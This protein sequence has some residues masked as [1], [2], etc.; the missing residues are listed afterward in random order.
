MDRL[1]LIQSLAIPNTTKILLLIMDGLGGLPITEG[2][3]TELEAANT[4][5]LDALTA[6]GVCG[7]SLPIAQGITPGSGP[8]HMALFGYDPLAYE[9]GRGVLEALGIGFDLHAEDVAARGNFCTLDPATGVITDRRAGRIPTSVCERLVRKLRA[10]RLPGVEVFVE[11]VEDYRF[12]LIL[13]GAGLTDGLTETDPQ[14]TGVAPLPVEPTRPEAVHTAGLLNDWLAEAFKLLADERPANGCTLRGI[15]KNP[16][17]PPMPQV[18][19]LRCGAIATYPMYRGIAKLA[20]MDVLPTGHTIADEVET[21]RAH[22]ADYDFF[23]FHVKKTDSAGED[24]DFAR[25][26]H[27]IEE[28]DGL[29][30]DILALNPDVVLVTGDHSTPAL[31]KAHSWHEL[32]VLLWS[33]YCR[34]DGVTRFGERDCLAGG[35]GHIHHLDL[36]PLA[37]AHAGRLAKFGA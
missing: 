22:W 31:W 10:I 24:G 6:R 18:Y 19:G 2:G 5:N 27:V 15:A 29:L 17:L 7:M 30:P 4:P 9:I 20:G 16:G 25:K 13:R 23:F 34:P 3:P 26:A 32:P 35:L 14:R 11:P 36:M 28:L 8:G 12:A 1:A 37:L 33:R 21:L